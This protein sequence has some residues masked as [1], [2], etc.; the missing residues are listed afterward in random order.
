MV[1]WVIGEGPIYQSSLPSWQRLDTISNVIKRCN[2]LRFEFCRIHW[3]ERPLFAFTKTSW[4]DYTES[5]DDFNDPKC[6]VDMRFRF[7]DIFWEMIMYSISGINS[8]QQEVIFYFFDTSL[9]FARGLF[10]LLETLAYSIFCHFLQPK[11]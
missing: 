10:Y 8:S 6:L 2:L 4:Q 11:S 5:P 7:S 9:A 3:K 1:E